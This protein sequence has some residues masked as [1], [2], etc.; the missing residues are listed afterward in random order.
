M[1][2]QN[3]DIFLHKTKRTRQAWINQKPVVVPGLA[4]SIETLLQRARQGQPSTISTR[5]L[6]TVY[7]NFDLTDIHELGEAYKTLKAQLDEKHKNFNRIKQQAQEK[8]KQDQE[9]ILKYLNGLEQ[10]QQTDPPNA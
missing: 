9:R 8:A 3:K 5:T 4:P 6:E 2:D 10:Q 1:K 7:R